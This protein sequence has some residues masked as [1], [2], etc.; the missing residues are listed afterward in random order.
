ML[1]DTEDCNDVSGEWYVEWALDTWVDLLIFCWQCETFRP[2]LLH[3]H[4]GYP[5]SDKEDPLRE[6][7]LVEH[8]RHTNALPS[9][10]PPQKAVVF[11]HLP[12]QVHH[13]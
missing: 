13:L 4:A 5:E 8:E 3:E 12:S 1:G 2:M 9:A 11:F 6:A 7:L 10:P